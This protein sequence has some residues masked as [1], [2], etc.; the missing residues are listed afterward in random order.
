MPFAG[1]SLRSGAHVVCVLAAF[2]WSPLIRADAELP[3]TRLADAVPQHPRGV[4]FV[5]SITGRRITD[6]DTDRLLQQADAI[7]SPYR[8]RLVSGAENCLP[9]MYHG[10]N[11]SVRLVS[12]VQSHLG[13]TVFV[14]GEPRLP[15]TLS[16]DA[17]HGLVRQN[18]SLLHDR[19]NPFDSLRVASVALGRA[20]AH[21]LG[22]ILFGRDHSRTG[23]MRARFR[24]ADIPGE[25]DERFSLTSDQAVRLARARDCPLMR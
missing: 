24:P 19:N 22:H 11:I 5:V 16:V 2:L 20:L 9:G 13:A 18:P 23:L 21:E 14:S 15:I 12:D 25:P 10:P 8:M 7:W 1:A 17:A 3:S 4:C 6:V